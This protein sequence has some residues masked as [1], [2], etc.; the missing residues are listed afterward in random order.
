MKLILSSIF[1]LLLFAGCGYKEAEIIIEK[2][3][4]IVYITPPVSFT[5]PIDIPKPISEDIYLKMNL[6]DKEKE[7]GIYTIKLL[8]LLHIENDKKIELQKYINSK[9]DIKNEWST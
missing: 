3:K 8:N 9:E 1:I 2:E 4:E 7:L 6:K 5:K